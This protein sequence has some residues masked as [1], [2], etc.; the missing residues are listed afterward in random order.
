MPQG[1]SRVR[2]IVCPRG[3]QSRSLV[4]R[5][6]MRVEPDRRPLPPSRSRLSPPRASHPDILAEIARQVPCSGRGAP[7]SL[8][9]NRS[10][11]GSSPESAKTYSS[12]LGAMLPLQIRPGSL[13]WVFA[14]LLPLHQSEKSDD[15]VSVTARLVAPKTFEPRLKHNGRRPRLRD[16]PERIPWGVKISERS[17]YCDTQAAAD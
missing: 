4:N 13:P 10:C 9:S 14:R 11:R 3:S 5:N 15:R 1:R 17:R 16:Q 8:P 2:L 6:W 12:V 7:S